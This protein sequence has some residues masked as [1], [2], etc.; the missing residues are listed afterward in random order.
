MEDNIS[1]WKILSCETRHLSIRYP[2]YFEI[3]DHETMGI[4][5]YSDV[6]LIL[7]SVEKDNIVFRP[8]LVFTS[9]KSSMPLVDAAY[10]A[11]LNANIQHEQARV[12]SI[13]VM[14]KPDTEIPIGRILTFVYRLNYIQDVIVKK[15]VFAT[16]T[17]HIHI[18]ASYLPSQKYFIEET[19]DRIVWNI[20]FKDALDNLISSSKAESENHTPIDPRMPKQKLGFPL[21]DVSEFGSAEPKRSRPVPEESLEYILESHGVFL[22]NPLITVRVRHTRYRGIYLAYRARTGVVVIRNTGSSVYDIPNEQLETYLISEEQLL[23]DF[24]DWAKITPRYLFSDER[25]LSIDEYEQ[26]FS[27]EKTDSNWHELCISFGDITVKLLIINKKEIFQASMPTVGTVKLTP[28]PSAIVTDILTQA[29]YYGLVTH[30]GLQS[31]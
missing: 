13:D 5:S 19:I 2:E 12:L 1:D 21:E 22:L 31:S 14:Q 15:W 23:R 4:S 27:A 10:A 17:H 9:V 16:G 25:S 20:H 7:A 30:T 24:V 26:Y 29:I 28:C 3:L 11:Y 8:N 18:S 6:D